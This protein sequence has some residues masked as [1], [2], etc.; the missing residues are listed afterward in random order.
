MGAEE[1]VTGRL[2]DGGDTLVGC[3]G[4]TSHL[5]DADLDSLDAEGRCVVTMHEIR[6]VVL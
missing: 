4:A 5:S 1:G 6:S 2:S 3:Y